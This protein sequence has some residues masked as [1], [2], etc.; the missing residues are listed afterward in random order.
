MYDKYNDKHPGIFP[1]VILRNIGGVYCDH[2]YNY[3][4]DVAVFL[5][6]ITGE[7]LVVKPSIDTGSGKNVR[8]FTRKDDAYYCN[9]GEKLTLEY[10]TRS[11]GNNYL[12]QKY[13][14]QHEYFNAFNK[15]SLNSIRVTTY[16]SVKTEEV[17]VLHANLRM[18]G[19]GSTV[20]NVNAGG[21]AVHIHPDGQVSDF[22]SDKYGKKT[23]T[24]P[25]NPELKFSDM[26][27]VPQF[28]QM[29]QIAKEIAKNYFYF[30]ML[31]F[32]F[33]L[34]DN[35]Q[36]QLIEINFGGLGTVFQVDSGSLYGD[37][38]DEVIEYCKNKGKG[39]GS[40]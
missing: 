7:K 21:A 15:S 8:F 39:K 19:E 16:R 2:D 6:A 18:G 31:G 20:D 4:G 38:T 35:G 12:V 14:R 26:G 5:A 1:H 23:Y 37:L 40:D 24:P 34:R 32:D 29:K 36:V 22:A 9:D 11:Y 27:P 13:I 10:L 25:S 3:I 33:C 17:T 28:E 30:R